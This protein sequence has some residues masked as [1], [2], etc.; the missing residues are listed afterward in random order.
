MQ[1]ANMP[2][3]RQKYIVRW[4]YV[5]QWYDVV[6]IATNAVVKHFPTIN[7]AEVYIMK[8]RGY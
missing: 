8:V 7:E 2:R 4:N 5:R 1:G 6:D 3:N